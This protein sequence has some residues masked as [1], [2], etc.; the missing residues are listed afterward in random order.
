[1]AIRT[2]T[3]CLILCAGAAAVAAAPQWKA[4]AAK[5]VITPDE[6]VW[7]GGY[8]SRK[9]P[10]EGKVH[11][12]HAKALAVE[13]AQGNRFV[14]VTTDL[15]VITPELRTGVEDAVAERHG[16]P[17]DALMMNA[18]HTHCGPEIREGLIMRRNGTAA[19]AARAR[20]YVRKLTGQIV[21][22]IDNAVA[23]MQSAELTY[24][25]ARAGFAMNRRRP[26]DNGIQNSPFPDGPVDHQVPVLQI[27]SGSGVGNLTTVVFGYACHNTTLS[28]Q[29]LCGDYAGFAQK[30]IEEAHPGTIAMFLAGCGGD[31]NP[32]PRGTLELCQQH[33][34]AL[35]NSV[36]TALQAK[37]VRAIDGPVRARLEYVDL[38]FAEP[39]SQEQLQQRLPTE[40]GRYAKYTQR[41]LDQYAQSGKPRT[42]Y[43]FPLQAIQFGDDLTLIALCGEAVVDYSLRLRREL[44]ESSTT[45]NTSGSVVWVAGYSNHVFGYLPSR[46]VLAEGGYEGGRAM[47]S[48]NFPGPFAPS[49]EDRIVKKT[50]ELVEQVRN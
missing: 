37:S 50:R 38:E 39:P 8:A 35:A 17:P 33:G 42:T 13:D 43:P 15:L 12:L 45:L 11:N 34:R 2:L 21:Q 7:M 40:S 31:Q 14:L 1:M 41:L 18:S 20:V 22:V 32:Y 25:F 4:G 24:S 9:A 19:F 28:F 27:K 36:E 44:Q 47:I 6:P 30:Y 3:F 10:S 23:N 49:V 48:T 29:K 46:R 16:L 26:T 5:I